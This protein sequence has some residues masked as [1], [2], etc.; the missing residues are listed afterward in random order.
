MAWAPLLSSGAHSRLRRVKVEETVST[1]VGQIR[2]LSTSPGMEGL[3]LPYVGFKALS[4]SI[5]MIFVFAKGFLTWRS[6]IE[7]MKSLNL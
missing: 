5:F 7:F 3:K 4:F 6:Q 1:E 2:K